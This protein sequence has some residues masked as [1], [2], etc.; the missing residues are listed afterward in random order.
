MEENCGER[1]TKDGFCHLDGG[2]HCCGKQS[3]MEAVTAAGNRVEW[4]KQIN[5]PILP[6]ES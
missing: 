6:E 2:C 5:G 1:E 3:R 4:R